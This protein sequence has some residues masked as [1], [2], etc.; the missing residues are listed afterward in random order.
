MTTQLQEIF[1][2]LMSRFIIN[3]PESEISTIEQVCFQIEQAHWFY[4][5]FIR[6]SQPNLPHFKLKSFAGEMFKRCPLLIEFIEQSSVEEIYS[7]FVAYKM[8]VPVC[9]AILLNESSDKV[10]LVKGWGSRGNWTFPKGKINQNESD[11]D[12]A[13]REVME[14]TGFDIRDRIEEGKFIEL[15]LRGEQR[16]KMFVIQNISEATQFCP[17]T[18][19]EI[20]D[21]KWHWLKDLPGYRHQTKQFVNNFF[22]IQRFMG[23]LKDWLK[24]NSKTGSATSQKQNKGAQSDNISSSPSHLPSV[25]TSKKQKKSKSAKKVQILGGRT[26]ND[27]DPVQKLLNFDTQLSMKST[28]SPATAKEQK[29]ADVQDNSIFL[30]AFNRHF[31]VDELMILVE[32][33]LQ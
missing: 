6:E 8:N 29:T 15:V 17:Q 31:N 24:Q 13:V 10:L 27:I 9:G 16:N 4:E 5:D 1:E 19:K 32:Q 33:S 14:E 7:R 26:A 25:S 28:P 12:C 20:G 11:V 18:R 23:K 21:I 3:V 2:D 22:M 30:K